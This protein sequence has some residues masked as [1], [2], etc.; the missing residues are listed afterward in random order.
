M[1][2]LL[3]KLSL[4]ILF[5]FG[6]LNI[7]YAN[8]DQ[9]TSKFD[10]WYGEVSIDVKPHILSLAKKIIKVDEENCQNWTGDSNIWF[11]LNSN[12]LMNIGAD[13]FFN[14]TLSGEQCFKKDRDK[15]TL[16]QAQVKLI[17]CINSSEE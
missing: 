15:W 13:H 10:T 6:G 16:G 17:S 11:E 12:R 8:C 2:A 7:S 3:G 4:S 9:W 14:M 1:K 5:V